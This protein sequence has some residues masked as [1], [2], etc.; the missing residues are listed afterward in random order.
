M[1]DVTPIE[2]SVVKV[3]EA[4]TLKPTETKTADKPLGSQEDAIVQKIQ[5]GERDSNPDSTL[6]DIARSPIREATFREIHFGRIYDHLE[7]H[8]VINIAAFGKIGIEIDEENLGLER[9]SLDN[10][11]KGWERDREAW[12]KSLAEQGID[13]D[14]FS[15]YK[16]YQI[17][18]KVFQTLGEPT[19]NVEERNRRFDES[20]NVINLSET[21]GYAMC[22]EYA[23]LS[24]YCNRDRTCFPSTKTLV[25]LTGKSRATIF[26]WLQELEQK[27]VIS[28]FQEGRNRIIIIYDDILLKK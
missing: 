20:G 7:P 21:K 8:D 5:L 10:L 11:Q 2:Q 9:I 28:K 17:Q 25:N 24:T 23:I 16:Y 26:R 22:S 18:R 3:P 6:K 4:V 15:V 1:S 14:P 12:S 27:K 19:T 13:L